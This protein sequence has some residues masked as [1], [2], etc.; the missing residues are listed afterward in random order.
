MDESLISV[1][2]NISKT[3]MEILITGKGGAAKVFTGDQKFS[4]AT[5]FY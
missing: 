3:E 4:L 5:K 2:K 1:F